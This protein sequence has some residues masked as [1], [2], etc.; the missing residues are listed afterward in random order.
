MPSLLKC[1]FP[2]EIPNR[3]VI[4]IFHFL[5]TCYVHLTS[6]RSYKWRSNIYIY[7]IFILV[8]QSLPDH[9]YFVFSHTTFCFKTVFK[10]VLATWLGESTKLH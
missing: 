8:T 5:L 3:N 6:P 1:F 7:I 4:R 9:M 10:E 2:A